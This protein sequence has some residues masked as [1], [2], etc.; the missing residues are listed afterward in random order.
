[1]SVSTTPAVTTPYKKRPYQSGSSRGKFSRP[2]RQAS[3]PR[4]DTTVSTKIETDHIPP[5]LDGNIRIINL[6]G[7]EEIGRNMT[8]IEYKD[9]ILVIDCGVQSTEKHTPGVDYILPNTK[10][11][12]EH[13]HKIKGMVVTHGHL[14]HIGAIPYILPRIGNPQIYARL[15]TSLM[16]KKR[17]EEFPHLDPI[18]INVIEKGETINIGELKI[19]F[20][21]INHAIPDSM[22]VVIETPYGDIVHTGSIRLDNDG[23]KPSDEE[24]EKF[25][26]FENRKT[27]LLLSDSIDSENLGFSVSD[28]EVF[29]KI[30]E[31]ISGTNGRL[32]VASF[33]SRVEKILYILESAE[34]YGK[35]IVIEEKSIK[36]II[37]TAKEINLLKIRPETFI[38]IDEINNYPENKLVILSMGPQ[39]EEFF[40]LEKMANRT[41]KFI[42]LTPKDTILISSSFLPG[43]K[44]VFQN[45]QDKLSRCG[46]RLMHYKTPDLNSSGIHANS[47]E[48]IWMHKKIHPKF[49]IPV[50][51]YH[52]MLRI[53]ADIEKRLGMPEENI[54]IPDNGMIIEIQ[55]SGN[56]MIQLKEKA[57]NDIIVVDGTSVGKIQDIVIRDRQMLEEDGMFVVIGVIDSVT[58]TLK[59]SPDLISR[60]FVYLKESQ[61]LLYQTRLLTKKV[62]EDS[63]AKS[64]SYLNLDQMK[65]DVAETTTKFLLQQT[66]KRPVIIPVIISV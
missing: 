60:G 14:D 37:E 30:D 33:A 4:F 28:R 23:N 24:V 32:I 7:V 8:M 25:K 53:H 5:L 64:G 50:Q 26:F 44:R 29:K 54:I 57:P 10:Y 3:G 6:G 59:K 55:D 12:E 56:K 48:L 16:I 52:Y 17:Q 61:D 66:A 35:K 18:T 39:R 19:H 36:L 20:F 1:M 65:Q 2:L 27:L 45:L 13:K 40:P 21:G 47:E 38:N 63:L 51:G 49:F 31:I 42:K 11:L 34:K 58:K 62:I 46:A 41:H 22:G 9:T 43:N 15:F